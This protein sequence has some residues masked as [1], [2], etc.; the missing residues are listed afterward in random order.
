MPS[1]FSFQV[2]ELVSELPFLRN[3]VKLVRESS[4]LNSALLMSERYDPSHFIL[5][6]FQYFIML[7]L[8]DFWISSNY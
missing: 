2:A 4:R 8:R 1:T 3:S 6:G 7:L 5:E